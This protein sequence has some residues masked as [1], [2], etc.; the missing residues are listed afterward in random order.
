[1]IIKIPYR[2]GELM[3]ELWETR[4]TIDPYLR[5]AESGTIETMALLTFGMLITSISRVDNGQ[6][7]GHVVYWENGMIT[8]SEIDGESSKL[9][10]VIDWNEHRRCPTQDECLGFWETAVTQQEEPTE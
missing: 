4:N 5:F 8:V 9:L 3:S 7:V 6:Q 2:A 10:E 1:M